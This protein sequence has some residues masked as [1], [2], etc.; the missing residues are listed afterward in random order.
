MWGED[1]LS[2]VREDPKIEAHML[3]I[4]SQ[5]APGMYYRA[6][7]L[8]SL[9]LHCQPLPS[10]FLER[11]IPCTDW[12]SFHF[13]WFLLPIWLERMFY[14]VEQGLFTG[15]W[16]FRT[17]CVITDQKIFFFQILK[18]ISK[19]HFKAA[20]PR[21]IPN[22]SNAFSLFPKVRALKALASPR[23]SSWWSLEWEYSPQRLCMFCLHRILTTSCRKYSLKFKHSSERA[24]QQLRRLNTLIQPQDQ[25]K[26]L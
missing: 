7:R 1:A 26:T 5:R 4:E 18:V 16:N 12:T 25:E 9:E 15:S 24:Q 17:I 21:E 3:W 8:T 2:S 13:I 11:C 22:T 20:N 6:A 10:H 23:S 14:L 19:E